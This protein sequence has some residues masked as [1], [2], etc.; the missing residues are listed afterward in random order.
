MRIAVSVLVIAACLFLMQAAARVGFS[1]LLARYALIADSIPAADEA[2]RLSP[3]DPE[4]HRAR[5]AVLSRQQKFA[6]ALTSLEVA[7]SL[8][9]RDDLLWLE[10]G[11]AREEIGDTKG[12]LDAFDQAVRWAPHYAHVHWQRGN[13]L[14]RMGRTDE[15]FAEMR[16]AT[17]ANKSYFPTLIDLA[18][19]ISGGNAKRAEELIEIKDDNQRLAFVMFL[20]R[21]GSFRDAHGIWSGVKESHEPILVNGGFEEPIVFDGPEFGRWSFS[22]ER[23]KDKFAIDI[24][25]KFAGTRSLKITLEGN[26]NPGSPLLS[27]TVL[28]DPSK[29]Y[30]VSFNVRT[31]DLVTGGPPMFTVN[32]ATNNELLG[33][34]EN[35]PSTAS[36]LTLNFE[37]TTLATSEAAVIRLQRNNCEPSPCPIFGVVWLDEIEIKIHRF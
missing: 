5:A 26:W 1:R 34:S 31:K 19:G 27:Q 30:R 12:A 14:L 20:S 21:K 22:N 36:W 24:S 4:I 3:S 7:S 16:T 37:F 23:T 10:L 11:N 18:W 32:D 29:R 28:V 33:K 17:A 15:A 8:R 13:L 35:F 25:E 6:E 9:Y 2:A